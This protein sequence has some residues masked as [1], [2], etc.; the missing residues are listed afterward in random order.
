MWPGL[1][2]QG[3]WAHDFRPFFQFFWDHNFVLQNG[4]GMKFLTL[5]KNLVGIM[6]QVTECIYVVAVLRYDP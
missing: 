5:N 6:M 4:V 1:R 2:K 3:M